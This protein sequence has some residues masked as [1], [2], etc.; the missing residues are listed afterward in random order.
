MDKNAIVLTA[1]APA[2]GAAFSPVQVQK[3]L[4]LI[5]RNIADKVDGP[6]FNFQPYDYGPFDAAVYGVLDDLADEE[7][8]E[9]LDVPGQSWKRYR[10]TEAGQ[11]EGGVFFN[12]IND[13]NIRNYIETLSSFVLKLTF[14]QLV[15]A[16][17]KA[18]PE[19]KVNSVFGANE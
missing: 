19:M 5:E 12:S 17:Y 1:L 3:L 13:K 11:I 9:V 2:Q 8:I 10:L 7:L 4:F 6:H 14:P 18:Y 15:S 16:V